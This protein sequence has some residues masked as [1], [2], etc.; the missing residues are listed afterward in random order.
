MPDPTYGSPE[1]QQQAVDNMCV[2]ISR[3]EVDLEKAMISCG[4][5]PKA[6]KEFHEWIARHV[7]MMG[8]NVPNEKADAGHADVTSFYERPG[9][10]LSDEG[11]AMATLRALH[12]ELEAFRVRCSLPAPHLGPLAGGGG[13]KG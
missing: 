6:I 1:A 11:R 13:G 10:A 4:A 12:L 5:L 8:N 9:D 7:V 2:A 3:A